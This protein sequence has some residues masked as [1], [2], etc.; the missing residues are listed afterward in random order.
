MK[1]FITTVA[2]LG[3]FAMIPLW[4]AA[5]GPAQKVEPDPPELVRGNTTFGFDLYGQLARKDGNL[6]FSPY[7]IPTALAMTYD[8]ARGQ[9]AAEMAKTLHF[10]PDTQHLNP[11]FARIIK[12]VNGS[13]KD[14]PFQLRVA[15][16][17]WGQKG[18]GFLPAFLEA[19]RTNYG[20]GLREVDFQ[21]AAE[22]ARQ[23]INHW[24]EQQTNDKIKDILQPKDV[25]A[26][27]RLVLTNAIY[28]KAPWANPFP[29][30]ATKTEDFRV[31]A[32]QKVKVPMMHQQERLKY[33]DDKA[34]QLLEL[35]YKGGQQSML[36]FLPKK[37]TGLAAVEKAME[38]TKLDGWLA[39]MKAETVAVALPRFKFTQRFELGKTL[40]EMGMPLAFAPNQ[41]DFSGMDGRRDLFIGIVIHQA[42][43]DVNEK[44]TEA[45]AA[46]AVGMRPASV[47]IKV[48]KFQADHPF[49]FAI[50]DRDTGSILF[51]GRVV[52]PHG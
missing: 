35:P 4:G 44:G 9:T 16:A 29:D 6:F 2:T 31:T 1:R 12:E 51:L 46:T 26:D 43:V 15:N 41:A 5:N 3:V 20:A 11:A 28:F 7:S 27:S 22:E 18:F 50:R 45:A 37:D 10:F 25:G 39:K 36:V 21:K 23:T 34:F 24:V 40:A 13:G 47:P 42:F 8:G 19:V 48:V 30:H 49:L 32:D 38:T 52:N 17:L 14:R 33:L